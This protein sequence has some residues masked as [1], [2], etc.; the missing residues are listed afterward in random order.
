[1][2]C[3][4]A[5]IHSPFAAAFTPG[6]R[7]AQEQGGTV[8][9]RVREIGRLV[10]PTGRIVVADPFTMDFADPPAPLSRTGPTGVFPIELA[11]ARFEH[12]DERVACAR[13][14]FA[15][16]P[17]VRWEP[18]GFERDGQVGWYGVDS[19]TGCFFDEAARGVVDDA[20][21]AEW[22]AAHESRRVDTWAWHVADVGAANVAMFSSGWGDGLY[23]TY[24]GLA[25]DGAVVELVTDFEVLVGPLWERVE[26]P[27]PLPFGA[28]AHPLL[29]A[30]FV[31]LRRPLLSRTTAIVG[32]H[33]SAWVELS[34]GSPVSSKGEPTRRMYTWDKPGPGV[35]LVVH[36]A[37][38]ARPLAAL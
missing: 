33:G 31:T 38:G 22:S 4:R 19:G 9:V 5:V 14:R 23:C 10:V 16:A 2:V 17:A 27:L 3:A 36:V 32:G 11:V 35:R 37:V 13:V 29:A 25:A 20:T 1:M 21:A 8:T 6:A 30:H 24:W 12:G 7:F 18:A 15:E 26:L 28:C 34:D